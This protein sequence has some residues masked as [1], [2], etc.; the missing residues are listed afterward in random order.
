MKIEKKS[1]P[2][3]KIKLITGTA[4]RI[5]TAPHLPKLHQ[6]CVSVAK[7]GS[8]KTTAISNLLRMYKETGTMERICILS[9]TFHSN[10][11]ILEQLNIRPEDIWDDID[12]ISVVDKIRAICDEERDDF[13]R[14]KKLK[15]NYDRIM[16]QIDDGLLPMTGEYDDYLMDYYDVS[17]NTFRMPE[18][19]YKCYLE[20]RPPVVSVIMDDVSGG[21]ICN[22]KALVKLVKTHRHIAP[23][24]DGGAVGVSLY[25]L[26]QTYKAQNGLNKAIRSQICTALIGRSR[27]ADEMK[28]IAESFAGEISPE[29][30]LK[31]HHEATKDSPHDFLFVDLHP[32]EPYQ[33]FR[34]NFDQ[35]LIVNED[36]VK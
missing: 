6:V 33:Q 31:V 22:S 10:V 12:D 13:L 1:E 23:T 34:K 17:R 15:A 24:Y 7:R 21:A 25:F 14:Y 27:C 4:F 18:P 2:K 30:F 3:A 32:K 9:P 11:K 35:Y 28:V 8:F 36:G 19:K 5:E 26:V 16:K 20:G 29:T